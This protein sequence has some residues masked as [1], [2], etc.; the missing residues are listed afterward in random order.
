MT[1]IESPVPHDTFLEVYNDDVSRK[2]VAIAYLVAEFP[3][4]LGENIRSQ[5]GSVE[6]SLR[7]LD[8][9]QIERLLESLSYT[10]RMNSVFHRVYDASNQWVDAELPIGNISLTGT[11]PHINDIVYSPEIANSPIA[12]AQYLSDYFKEHE[13]DDP[14]DLNEFRA[15]GGL[16]ELLATRLIT[17]QKLDSLEIV[18]GTHRLIKCAML[19]ASSVRAYVALPSGQESVAMKGDSTFLTLR[20]AFEIA[21]SATEQEYLLQACKLLAEDSLDGYE[22]I[23]VYW[24]EHPRDAAIQDAGRRILAMLD[25]K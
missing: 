3:N 1:S 22:A 13:N 21:S 10:Y 2:E 7:I 24:I 15:R 20:L 14:L 11:K 4:I 23:K 12:F 6:D 17:A 25:D 16:E 8:E 19:G 5:N 9:K 18:D